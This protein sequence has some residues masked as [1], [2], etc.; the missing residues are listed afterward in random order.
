MRA[1]ALALL[2]PTLALGQSSAPRP[3]DL[4]TVTGHIMCADTQ[5]PA[6]NAQVSLIAIKAPAGSGPRHEIPFTQPGG[7]GPVHTDFTGGYTIAGV[8]PGQYYLNVELPGYAA[9]ISQFTIEELHA[10]T[11]EIQQRIQRDFQL[12]TVTPNS[13]MQADATIRRAGSISGTVIW[14]DGSPAIDIGIRIVRYDAKNNH[15]NLERKMPDT[16]TDSHGQFTVESLLSGEYLVAAV[17][18]ANEQLPSQMI[19]PD[20]TQKD[21]LVEAPSLFMPIYSPGVFRTKDAA[22]VKVDAGQETDGVDVTIPIGRLH[23]IS[24]TLIAKDGHAISSGRVDLL[25]ADTREEFVGIW[26]HDHGTFRLPFIPDGSYILKVTNAFDSEMR[27][28]PN[29]PG[30]GS[31][32]HIEQHPTRMYQSYEQ[33]LIIH[34][35]LQSLNLIVPE[36]PSTTASE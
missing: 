30:S 17:V 10:P 35:D 29:S 11:P 18:T 32:T 28:V 25:F 19:F 31:V 34:T 21:I 26:A 22:I 23:Q 27:E 5:R 8:P 14:D 24:G 7:Q 2:L 33:P 3:E 6:R 4:G 36:K 12:V 15:P 16:Y 1:I 20:G 9:P 13:T